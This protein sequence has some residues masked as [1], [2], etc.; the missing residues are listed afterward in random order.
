MET[1]TYRDYDL[2]AVV[3]CSREQQ[4]D[5]AIARG[6]A[7]E[8]AHALLEAQLPLDEK[9]AVADVVIDNSGSREQLVAEVDRAWA[10]IKAW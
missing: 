7:E 1:G 4:L 3:W 2:L 6:V 10:E 5:R 8:R 9:R